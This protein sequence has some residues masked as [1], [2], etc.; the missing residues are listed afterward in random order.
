MRVAVVGAGGVGGYY[1]ALLARAGAQVCLL[2]RGPHLAAIRE[3]GLRVRS[4]LAG[5]WT[6]RPRATDDPSRVGPADLVLFCVKAYDLEAA[7]VQC[8]PMVLPDTLVIPV[9]NGIDAVERLQGTL[10]Q[11]GVLAGLTYVASRIEGP[12]VV[13]QRGRAD[14]LVCGEPAGGASGRTARVTAYF[15]QMGFPAQVVPDMPVRLW[16]KLAVVCA[17]GGVLAVLRQPFGPVLASPRSSGLLLGVM[18]EV[19][20]LARASGQPLPPEAPA[21]LLRYLQQT[22]APQAQSS[23]LTDLQQGRRLELE[24]LNGAAVRLGRQLGVPTPLNASLYAALAPF[25]AGAGQRPRRR[26]PLHREP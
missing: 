13:V 10:G 19:A 3:G 9:Q 22:M 7:A 6:V 21:R 14:T 26:L 17:T 20:A 2:A 16:E 24:H 15:Q 23:Q 5:D 12:G 25:A 8:R 11:G 18:Q 4:E 1:G